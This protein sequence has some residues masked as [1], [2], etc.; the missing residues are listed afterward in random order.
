MNYIQILLSMMGG[1]IIFM[2]S[3]INLL[4]N[5]LPSFFSQFFRYGKFA[6]KTAKSRLIIEVPKKW[7][8]HFYYL[9]II[10]FC[11]LLWLTIKVYIFKGDIPNYTIDIL[12][13][14][15]GKER[16]AFGK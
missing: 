11:L 9:A 8:R 7:F 14:L 4:E 15:C 12:N 13:F 10:Y 5:K 2:G 1:S 6:A 16:Y 3:L